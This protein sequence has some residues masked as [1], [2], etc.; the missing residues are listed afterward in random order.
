MAEGAEK[1]I[2]EIGG[3]ALFIACQMGANAVDEFGKSE[4]GIGH[5][6][7]LGKRLPVKQVMVHGLARHGERHF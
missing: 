3:L 4:G 7:T 6:L 5:M 1:V 2:E